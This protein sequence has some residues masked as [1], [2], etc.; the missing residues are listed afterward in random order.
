MHTSQSHSIESFHRVL[1]QVFRFAPSNELSSV[2]Y[3]IEEGSVVLSGSLDSRALKQRAREV[4]TDALGSVPVK[5][6]IE[7]GSDH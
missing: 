3:A 5:N 4:V 1:S 2:D 7:V 6:Q